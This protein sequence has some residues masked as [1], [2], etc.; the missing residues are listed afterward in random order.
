MGVL[1]LYPY[2]VGLGVLRF[3]KPDDVSQLGIY[4][5]GQIEFWVE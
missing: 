1:Y 2:I 3:K 4:V 5:A